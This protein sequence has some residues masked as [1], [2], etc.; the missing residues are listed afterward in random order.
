MEPARQAPKDRAQEELEDILREAETFRRRKKGAPADPGPLE[1]PPA[2][3]EPAV[4]LE[5]WGVQPAGAK[6]IPE[7]RYEAEQIRLAERAADAL[8]PR[9]K[10]K[11]TPQLVAQAVLAVGVALVW[12]RAL[13]TPASRPPEPLDPAYADASARWAM[14]VVS[15]RVDQFQVVYSRPPARLAEVGVPSSDS[16][17]Y[18]RI[19]AD[20]YRLAGPGPRGRLVL[21]SIDPRPAFLGRSL[22]T[23]GRAA[24]PGSR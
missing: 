17:G 6:P 11:V 15:Q 21:N 24:V 20:E 22:E 16:V 1:P 9:E 2:E 23:L 4:V 14:M 19:S 12:L 18:A 8:P 3:A 13:T 5:P 7:I 10:F